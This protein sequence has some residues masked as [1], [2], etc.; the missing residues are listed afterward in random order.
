MAQRTPAEQ[1]LLADGGDITPAPYTPE[2]SPGQRRRAS[3]DVPLWYRILKEF[4]LPTALVMLLFARETRWIEREATR[5]AEEGKR[6]QNTIDRLTGVI[7]ANTKALD[8]LTSVLRS[9]VKEVDEAG[10]RI[11]Q[12]EKVLSL[13][14]PGVYIQSRKPKVQE[15]GTP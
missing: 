6:N 15:A 4:G 12:L 7:E 14:H 9:Q 10:E 13:A 8:A 2:L 1:P 5:S 11:L 3:A